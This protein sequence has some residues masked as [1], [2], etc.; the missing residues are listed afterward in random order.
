[1]YGPYV[2]AYNN[3]FEALWQEKLKKRWANQSFRLYGRKTS[4]LQRFVNSLGGGPRGVRNNEKVMVAYG[5]GGFPSGQRFE[6]Y[7]PVKRTRRMTRQTHLTAIIGEY[8]TSKMCPTCE[9]PLQ[10]V[11]VRIR[12]RGEQPDQFVFKTETAREHRRCDNRCA[13]EGTSHKN[14]DVVGALNILKCAKAG[15]RK[16]DVGSEKRPACLRR[17]AEADGAHPPMGVFLCRPVEE[18]GGRQLPKKIRVRARARM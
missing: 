6:R 18:D 15:G 7:V 14:R 16:A 10:E 3:N 4:V 13:R 2:N 8:N 9:V 11:K 12:R 1:M 17:R 5:D